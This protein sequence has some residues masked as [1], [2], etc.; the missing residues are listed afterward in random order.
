MSVIDDL[1]AVCELQVHES[2]ILT[3]FYLTDRDL[4]EI[5]GE[6]EPD[7]PH[8]GATGR[9]RRVP[10]FL[11]TDETSDDRA[12]LKRVSYSFVRTCFE[13]QF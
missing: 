10:V 13:I 3:G 5:A 12:S 6:L 7:E 11:V 8:V 1:N 9:F 2:F 4:V